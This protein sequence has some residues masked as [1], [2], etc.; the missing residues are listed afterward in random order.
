MEDL[1]KSKC[2]I[3]DKDIYDQALPQYTSTACRGFHYINR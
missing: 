2:P 1:L 3:D